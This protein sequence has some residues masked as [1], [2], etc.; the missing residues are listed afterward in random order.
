MCKDRPATILGGQSFAPHSVKNTMIRKNSCLWP[1]DKS[2][3]G[4]N[5]RLAD[6]KS[7]T[8]KQRIQKHKNKKKPNL[9]KNKSHKKQKITKI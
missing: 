6:N 2:I 8:K 4:Q 7:D 3:E 9:S 1:N 5:P